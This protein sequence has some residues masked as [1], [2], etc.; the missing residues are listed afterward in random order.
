MAAERCREYFRLAFP[1]FL[2]GAIPC[3]EYWIGRK[4]WRMKHYSVSDYIS[5]QAY[6]ILTTGPV[7][8]GKYVIRLPSGVLISVGN[9][10]RFRDPIR[11]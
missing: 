6:E 10:H 8:E 5:R 7:N 2:P 11:E 1:R 4:G 3:V 9:S